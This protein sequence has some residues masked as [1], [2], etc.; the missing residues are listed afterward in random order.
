MLA[1]QSL[2]VVSSVDGDAFEVTF[3]KVFHVLGDVLKILV[4]SGLFA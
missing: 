2:L 1:R 3:L 4:I